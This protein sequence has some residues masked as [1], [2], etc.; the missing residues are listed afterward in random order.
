MRPF[1]RL[2]PAK[3]ALK[4]LLEHA[5]PIE[6]IEEV[7]ILAA[8]GRVLAEDVIAP[9]DIPPF[10]RAAEDG[11]AVR[12]EDTFGASRIHPKKLK[13]IGRVLAGES[14]NVK[15]EPNTAV[16][17]AT[18]AV[19]PEG[20]NAVVRVEDTELD[21]NGEFVIIYA[22]VHPGFDVSKRGEDIKKGQILLKRG[23][24]LKPA[25]IGALAAVG[26]NRV[27]VFRKP[28]IAIVPTGD[29]LVEPG[30]KLQPGKIYDV[31]TYTLSAIAIE[32][33][34]IPVMVE[35]I[36]DDLEDLRKALERALEVA[37]LIVFSGG[38]SVG[39]RDFLI[40][41]F[42]E[43][44]KVLFHGVKIKPG[45]PTLA[46]IIND[47]LVLGFPGYPTSC[48]SNAYYFL[49]PLI[50][51]LARLPEKRWHIV[52]GRMA[53]R[54]TS[55]LGRMQILP[56]RINGDLVESAFKE[57]GAITSM[58]NAEGLV[59]IPEDVDLLEKGD[60]VDVYIID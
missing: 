12:A 38:S 20:A 50:R 39:V 41:I 26:L 53:H 42:E 11:Y 3:D 2:I 17:I 27:K 16:E 5:R 58:S 15:V 24:L 32:N 4:I 18:G 6:D 60:V 25:Q 54:I 30:K 29:E 31:N 47:K 57:S 40:N 51:K 19:L 14:P 44:G 46:A 59:Y 7:D 33:G 52:K 9:I 21:E 22:A 13:I 1:K 45:K 43:K 23:T 36:P 48:L 10:D 37:D 49:V 28:R 34:A 55:T 56:V 8:V 35:R